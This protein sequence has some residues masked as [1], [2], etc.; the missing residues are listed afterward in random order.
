MPKNFGFKKVLFL[1]ILP[2]QFTIKLD[3]QQLFLNYFILFTISHSLVE[4]KI[5]CRREIHVSLLYHKYQ[6]LYIIV[7]YIEI[8]IFFSN[9]EHIQR[10]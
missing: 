6:V 8:Y 4:I 5:V 3:C 7:D 10:M 2:L 1:N 9:K